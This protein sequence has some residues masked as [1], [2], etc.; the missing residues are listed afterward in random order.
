MPPQVFELCYSVN[1]LNTHCW[2]I[3]KNFSLLLQNEFH[4][5]P[6]NLWALVC[7]VLIYKSDQY[8]TYTLDDKQPYRQIPWSITVLVNQIVAQLI[9]KTS[10]FYKI[11]RFITMF[12][13]ASYRFSS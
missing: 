2:K 7:N 9:K 4:S 10:L 12:I 6:G 5:R 11:W 3:K 8:I 13:A 1:S